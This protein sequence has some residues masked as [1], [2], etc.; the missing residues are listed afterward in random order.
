MSNLRE[1]MHTANAFECLSCKSQNLLRVR[2]YR[3]NSRRGRDL[4]RDIS[5]QECG[6]CHLV[7]SI[8]RPAPTLLEEYYRE[9]Y[10]VKGYGGSDVADVG[11][12]PYDNLFYCNRAQSIAQLLKPYIF[13]KAP[14]ILDIGAGYG[15][16]LYFLGQEFPKSQR[17]A[18][19][20]SQPCVRH[21]KSQNIEVWSRPAE[22]IL[23]EKQAHFDVITLSHVLEHLLDPKAVLRLIHSSLVNGGVLYVEV[24]NIPFDSLLRYPDHMWAPRYDEPHITFFSE[25]SLKNLIEST[26]FTGEF[27]S[28]A[29]PFYRHVSA[30]RFHLPPFR[31]TVAKWLPSFLFQF[32][33][34]QNFT[35][36]VRVQQRENSFFEY[37]GYRL[38][39]RSVWRKV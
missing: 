15:H 1:P 18:V 12:F 7:Q 26:G 10:R 24:P 21:L 17:Y 31:E 35:G 25:D 36:P 4:F 8:P 2:P 38:W 27:L 34:K 19:E 33:R 11:R 6:N 22:E 20:F 28:T 13:N 32:L 5:L 30:L 3:A 16:I 39:I 29:G 23:E 9:D 37:G 14:H